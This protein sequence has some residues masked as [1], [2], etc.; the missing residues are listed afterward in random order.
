MHVD[1]VCYYK[2]YNNQTPKI[3]YKEKV[4]IFGRSVI[5]KII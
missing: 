3:L 1:L 2:I 5:R 4:F